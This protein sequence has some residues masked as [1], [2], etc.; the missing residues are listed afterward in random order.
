MEFTIE[1]EGSQI[2][3]VDKIY[4]GALKNG[5]KFQIHANWNDWDGWTVDDIVFESDEGEQIKEEISESFMKE[6]NGY[7]E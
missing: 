7:I 2:I 4:K 5:Q 1:F 6:M 3:S